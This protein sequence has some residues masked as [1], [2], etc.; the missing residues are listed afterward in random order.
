MEGL[1][2]S[3]T[4]F[5]GMGTFRSLLIPVDRRRSSRVF[6]SWWPINLWKY[7]MEF[8][9]K[10]AI[11]YA[12][13]EGWKSNVMQKLVYWSWQEFTKTI[14]LQKTFKLLLSCQIFLCVCVPD[15]KFSIKKPCCLSHCGFALGGLKGSA[16]G[17][18]VPI[19]P[20]N[21]VPGVVPVWDNG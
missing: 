6:V 7:K 5:K 17:A 1:D 4:R 8:L 3:W 14:L 12:Y 13:L 9:Y 15:K 2:N 21:V 18:I 10:Q 20:W 16:S 11:L 19:S